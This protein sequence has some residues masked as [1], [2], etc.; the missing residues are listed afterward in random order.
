MLLRNEICRYPCIYLYFSIYYLSP[1]IQNELIALCGKHVE[2][3]IVDEIKVAK[4]YSIIVD[5]TPDAAH[6][7]QNAFIK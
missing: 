6:I 5:A 3:R 2:T 4:Y 1:T 7:E